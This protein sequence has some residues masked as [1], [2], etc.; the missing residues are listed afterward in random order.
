MAEPPGGATAPE[1]AEG[2]RAAG[3]ALEAA[4]YEVEEVTPPMVE[5]AIVTWAQWLLSDLL[6]MKP[7]LELVLSADALRFLQITE[8]A[9]GAAPTVTDLVLAMQKR[10]EIARAWH[11]FFERYPVV[12]GPTWCQAPFTHGY[13][14]ESPTS[15]MATLE[16]IRFVTPM[17]LLGIPAACVPV[18]LAGGLPLGVQVVADRFREDRCL[19][20][21]AVLEEHFG[22]L[23]PID[24]R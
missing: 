6:V 14:I 21:A 8:D 20:T 7:I 10:F 1:V 22:L 15:A 11:S 4:G 2:V 12:V 24:P 23:T 3:R 5:D 13:D 18:G 9:M 17:N 16:M 19:A